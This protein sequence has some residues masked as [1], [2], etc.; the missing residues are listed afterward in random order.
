MCDELAWS[1]DSIGGFLL[2][3]SRALA[4]LGS[5]RIIARDHCSLVRTAPSERCALLDA[6]HLRRPVTCGACDVV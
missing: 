3:Q 6:V 4:R 2:H 1:I 5:D